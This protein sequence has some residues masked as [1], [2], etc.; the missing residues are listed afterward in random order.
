MGEILKALAYIKKKSYTK[1]AL[2]M[3]MIQCMWNSRKEKNAM[4]E[5]RLLVAKKWI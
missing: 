3:I 1:N 5:R 4:T 2:C